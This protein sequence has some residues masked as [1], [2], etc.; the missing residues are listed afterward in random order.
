MF[1]IPL[2][3]ADQSAL[4]VIDLQERLLPHTHDWQQVLEHVDWLVQVAQ[5]LGVPVAATEQ[6]PKGI[7]HTHAQVAAHLPAGATGEKIHFSCMPGN[8]LP[9]LPGMERQQVVVCGIESHVC[10]LQTVL[11]LAAAG[12]QVFVVAEA[13][14]SRDPAHKALALE[15]MRAHGITI[16]CREMVAFEWLGQAGTDQFRDISK[17]FLK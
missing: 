14:A 12:K 11:E 3:R 7:G 1:P 2:M 16:V 4:L 5:R 15:R 13:V 6:Y 17:N 10:V 8:C 9:K